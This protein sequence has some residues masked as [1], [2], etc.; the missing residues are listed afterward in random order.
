MIVFMEE[1]RKT[2]QLRLVVYPIIYKVLYMPGGAG[3][4]PTVFL[5]LPHT[6]LGPVFRYPFN[7]LQ[8]HDCRREHKGIRD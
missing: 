4:L 2:H 6:L 7:P 3:F 5:V 1:I 8:N